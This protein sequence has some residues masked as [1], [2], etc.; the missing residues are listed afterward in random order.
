V[1]NK[2]P[3]LRLLPQLDYRTDLAGN[4]MGVIERH[5]RRPYEVVLVDAQM[6]EMGGLE[7]S[8]RIIAKYASDKRPRV[9]AM[10]ANAMQGDREACLAADMDDYVAKPIQVDDLVQALLTSKARDAH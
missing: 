5:D 10:T 8:R 9:V 1:V 3:A 2:L 7:A 4:S 6:P